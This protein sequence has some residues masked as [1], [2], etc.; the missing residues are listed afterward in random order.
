MF[1]SSRTAAAALL[2]AAI[3]GICGQAPDATLVIDGKLDDV[4]WKPIELRPL[5]PAEDGVPKQLGGAFG[6]ALRGEWLCF[7]GRLPEP[8]GKVL[9]RAIGRDPVWQKDAY[10]APP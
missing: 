1:R 8:G 5:H 10:G 2:A 9:A 7:A 4:F 6:A 3:G